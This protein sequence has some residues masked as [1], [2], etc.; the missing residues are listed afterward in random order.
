MHLTDIAFFTKWSFVQPCVEQVYWCHFSN[1]IWLYPVSN[2][3]NLVI[4]FNISDFLYYY[5]GYGDMSSAISVWHYFCNYFGGVANHAYI[6]NWPKMYMAKQIRWQVIDIAVWSDCSTNLPSPQSLSLT[7]GLPNPWDTTVLNLGQFITL[8]W[9]LMF[10]WKE[11]S[12]ISHLKSKARN[13]Q[14]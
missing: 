9:P 13:N 1:N 8:K 10:R 4:F 5:I 2:V 12:R 14:A 6:Y 11:E 7:F 3:G